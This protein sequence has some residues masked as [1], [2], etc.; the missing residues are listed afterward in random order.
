MEVGGGLGEGGRRSRQSR[1]GPV[2]RREQAV[3]GRWGEGF[4][5]QAP[6]SISTIVCLMC[7]Q[8]ATAADGSHP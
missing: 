7:E 5:D 2:G 8:H 4:R 1:G 6:K 3:E